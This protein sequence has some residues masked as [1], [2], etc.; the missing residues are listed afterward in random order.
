MHVEFNGEEGMD[1]GGLTREWFTIIAKEI[2]NRDYALFNLS[3]TGNTYQ[4]NPKSG[5]NPDHLSYLKFI[6]R[7]IG[8]VYYFIFIYFI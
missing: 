3:S 2:F 6:G 7:I 4:P 1:A 8:K 5:I